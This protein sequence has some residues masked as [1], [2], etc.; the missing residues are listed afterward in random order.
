MERKRDSIEHGAPETVP[1]LSAS[2]MVVA[3]LEKRTSDGFD[4]K[5]LLLKR[6]GKSSTFVS[7]HV[8][9]GG[10]MVSLSSSNLRAT[11]SLFGIPGCWR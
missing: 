10:N 11:R 2:V 9:P 1:S 6:H 8:F 3:P 5:I 4:Y 7:A